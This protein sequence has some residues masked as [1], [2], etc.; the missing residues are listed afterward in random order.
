MLMVSSVHLPAWFA[1]KVALGNS[2]FF[3]QYFMLCF[4]SGQ[5]GSA[6][7][8]FLNPCSFKMDCQT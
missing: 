6:R 8:L 4:S 3:V 2:H 1:V 5:I 7:T